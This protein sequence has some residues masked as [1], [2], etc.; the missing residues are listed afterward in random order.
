MHFLYIFRLFCFRFL[1]LKIYFYITKKFFNK[2]F[3]FIFHL[4]YN[5]HMLKNI[6]DELNAPYGLA[7]SLILCNIFIYYLLFCRS[8]Y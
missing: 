6:T 1:I 5:T 3:V 4:Y 7:F 8:V 2:M